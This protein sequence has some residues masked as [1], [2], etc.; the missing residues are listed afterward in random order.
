MAKMNLTKD[1]DVAEVLSAPGSKSNIIRLAQLVFDLDG[2]NYFRAFSQFRKSEDVAKLITAK[3]ESI[4]DFGKCITQTDTGVRYPNN[5]AAVMVALELAT[6]GR[7]GEIDMR[8]IS[9]VNGGGEPLCALTELCP[10]H[11]DEPGVAV[12]EEAIEEEEEVAEEVVEEV[13]EDHYE[14]TNEAMDN[15][16][17]DMNPSVEPEPDE[18]LEPEPVD[19]GTSSA[20]IMASAEV[21]DRI[22]RLSSDLADALT[23]VVK[24]SSH[25]TESS[26]EDVMAGLAV[27]LENTTRNAGALGILGRN[28]KKLAKMLAHFDPSMEDIELEDLDGAPAAALGIAIPPGRLSSRRPNKSA[29]PRKGEGVPKEI[30]TKPVSS[31]EGDEASSIDPSSYTRKDLQ[32]KSRELLEEIAERVGVDNPSGIPYKTSLIK[33]I[34]EAIE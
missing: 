18:I 8:S 28:Q 24:L 17:E 16:T 23:Q 1:T 20:M 29:A 6:D 30:P 32:S 19:M 34:C 25:S 14:E 2:L 21:I 33:R 12:A 5:T 7:C 3:R 10:S 9:L 13:V 22:D 31:S 26:T 4:F 27:L 11:T 15:L